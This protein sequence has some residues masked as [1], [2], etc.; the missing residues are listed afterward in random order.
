MFSRMTGLFQNDG[1]LIICSTLNNKVKN[2]ILTYWIEFWHV[3]IFYVVYVTSFNTTDFISVG[4]R[5]VHIEP[6]NM[7]S[8]AEEFIIIIYLI[9]FA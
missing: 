6:S 7:R 4:S 3:Y 5:S 1:L 2:Y 9:I 8:A